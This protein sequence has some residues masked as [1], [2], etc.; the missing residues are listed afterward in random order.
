VI[1]DF[2]PSFK[3][4][5][6]I[7]ELQRECLPSVSLTFDSARPDPPLGEGFFLF[8][9]R[10]RALSFYVATWWWPLFRAK[11]ASLLWHAAD[12]VITAPELSETFFSISTA[13]TF[14]FSRSA[15]RC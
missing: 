11:A 7:H 1:N 10:H 12:R 3:L 6:R 14:L 4:L 8:W 5:R 15:Q 13:A 9:H 2:F